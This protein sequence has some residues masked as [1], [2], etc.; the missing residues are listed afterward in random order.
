MENWVG[1]T[2][3]RLMSLSRRKVQRQVGR[4]QLYGTER[5]T[6]SNDPQPNEYRLLIAEYELISKDFDLIVPAQRE[7]VTVQEIHAR[8]EVP[9]LVTQ[10]FGSQETVIDFPQGTGESEVP[11]STRNR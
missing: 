9:G 5:S 4:M 6:F 8:L 11:A 7:K 2:P 3:P 10:N 1:K